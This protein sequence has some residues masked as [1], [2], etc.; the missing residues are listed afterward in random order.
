MPTYLVVTSTPSSIKV[1][2]NDLSSHPD[3]NSL[4]ATFKRSELSEIW[5]NYEPIEHLKLKMNS[6]REWSLNLVG[7][8]GIF[9]V[10]SINGVTPAN[11]TELHN[12]LNNLFL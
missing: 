1:E 5:H 12:E 3:I 7:G 2:F 8:D 9:P 6:G 4:D 11:I 10:T